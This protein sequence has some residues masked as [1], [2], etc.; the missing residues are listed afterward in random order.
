VFSSFSGSEL[1]NITIGI[2]RRGIAFCDIIIRSTGNATA[3]DVFQYLADMERQRIQIFQN[4]LEQYLRGEIK[5]G[6]LSI[7][8]VVDYKIAEKLDQPEISPDMKLKDVFPLAANREKASIHGWLTPYSL[9]RPQAHSCHFDA[10]SW[11]TPQDSPRTAGTWEYSSYPGYVFSCRW[12]F[13]RGSGA[14]V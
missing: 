11:C 4:L 6:T 12:W 14:T 3:R 10:E 13:T 9:S 5:E 8:Q 7:G 1:I 2:E